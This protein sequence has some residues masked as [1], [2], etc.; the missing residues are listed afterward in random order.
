M[1]DFAT[2]AELE[3]FMGMPGSQLGARGTAILG[4]ASA[5]IRQYLDQDV[6]QVTG[7]VES[8]AAEWN[9]MVIRV[10]QVPVTAAAITVDAVA[11]TDFFANYTT[12]DFYRDD[13]APWDEGPIVITYDSGYPTTTNEF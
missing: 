9:K 5:E 2:V 4:Y 7:R 11:F 13:G 10:T 12:G 8:Y 1:A 3:Q 6:E